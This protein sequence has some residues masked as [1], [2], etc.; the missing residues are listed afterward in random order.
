MVV[1]CIGWRLFLFVCGGGG[2]LVGRMGRVG[3]VDY[4]LEREICRGSEVF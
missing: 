1:I 4:W 2:G 3:Y